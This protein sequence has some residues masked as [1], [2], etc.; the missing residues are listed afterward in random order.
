MLLRAASDAFMLSLNGCKSPAT[1][2]WYRRRLSSLCDFLGDVTLEEVTVDDLRRWRLS[3]VE[4]RTRYADHPFRRHPEPGG[5]SAHTLHGYVRA[6]RRFFQWLEDEERI[7]RNPARRLELPKLPAGRVRGIEHDDLRKMLSAAREIGARELA[8]CWFFYSTGARL[9]GVAGLTLDILKLERGVAYVTEKGDKTRPVFLLPEAIEAMRAYLAVRP[10]ES[11]SNRVF[12]G[13]RGPLTPGGIY[14]VM[15]RIALRAG[16]NHNWN[17]HNWRHR[18]LRDYQLRLGLGL[19][20]QLAGHAQESTTADMYGRM[21]ED[22]LAQAAASVPLP[23]SL[24]Q[25]ASAEVS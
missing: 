25:L 21:T 22:E 11:G 20:Q 15:E 24:M 4:R 12:L 6:A 7:A 8:L 1:L 16:V 18:R 3:L 19:V 23:L 17:P 14:E 9:A 5:L 13:L 10:V 2:D